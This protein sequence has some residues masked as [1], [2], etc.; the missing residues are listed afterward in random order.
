[1][2]LRASYYGLKKRIL[3]KVLGDY[4][5]TGVMTNKELTEF[6]KH[7]KTVL[8]GSASSYT[9]SLPNAADN[10]NIHALFIALMSS[11][12]NADVNVLAGYRI[13][14]TAG[15]IKTI[16]GAVTGTFDTTTGK[17]TINADGPYRTLTIIAN[18]EILS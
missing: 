18:A 7:T 15:N 16:A 2:A 3:D 17:F 8:L 10:N 14:D 6:A 12:G 1:M 11:T 13:G 9:F 5:A 4:D